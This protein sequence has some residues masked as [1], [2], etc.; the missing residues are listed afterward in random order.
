MKK[1]L[2]CICALVWL[3]A[4]FSAAQSTIRISGKIVDKNNSPLEFV[5]IVLLAAA[6][7]SM[8]KGTITDSEGKFEIEHKEP[9]T[10]MAMFS[11]LGFEKTYTPVFE[12]GSGEQAKQLGTITLKDNVTELKGVDVVAQKP[13]IERHTDKTVV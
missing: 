5:N 13:F 7:S 12:I 2:F 10:Y 3:F 1:T 8:V 4:S 6:D 9:G 11:Q